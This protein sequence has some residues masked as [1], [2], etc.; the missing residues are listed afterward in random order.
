MTYTLLGSW[1][2][3]H[4]VGL[5]RAA[6]YLASALMA[7]PFLYHLL[8]H[9]PAYLGLLEDDYF[10]YATVADRLVGIGRLSYD[11]STLT[12]GFHPL[13]FAVIAALRFACGGFGT[14]FY[15]TLTLVFL[16]AMIATYELG[17]RF[18]HALGASPGLAAALAAIYACGTGRLLSTG[19][20]CAL[21]VPLFLW[22]LIEVARPEPLTTRRAVRLGFLAS[23]AILARLDLALAVAIALGGWLLIVRPRPARAAS[24]L[25]AFGLGGALVPA[26][27]LAN[28]LGFGTVMPVSALAKRLI[29]TPGFDFSYARAVALGTYLGPTLFVLMPLGVLA[30]WQAARR[31][32]E[33]RLAVFTGAVVLLFAGVFFLIN[34]ETGWI[35]FGWYAYPLPVAAIVA[36]VYV[37]RVW[38]PRLPAPW[39]TALLALAVAQ[40]PVSAAVYYVQHGP[41]WTVADNGLLAMSYELARRIELRQ[42]LFAM[43]AVAGVAQYVA[44]KPVLQLEGIVTDRRMVE[45]VRDQDRLEDVLREYHADYLI[46]SWVGVPSP[47]H[48]DCWL[49]TQPDAQWAGKRTAKMHGEFCNQPLEHFY[50]VAGGNPWSIFPRVETFVWD[51]RPPRGPGSAAQGE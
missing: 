1:P 21:A 37:A 25:V 3:R 14:G 26:Y 38:G 4:A 19:M 24:L 39:A 18:A 32:R 10:Y 48:G 7:A 17:R 22:W 15:A 35:F 11:G 27:A 2:R 23:L 30:L 40:A 51:L 42:G 41:K 20:E 12:N 34:A 6:A 44:D 16:A 29:L 45:H 50:T 43:G 28:L 13:W 46:V 9:S 49:V 47:R 31:P 5:C 36:L 33:S 8:Q